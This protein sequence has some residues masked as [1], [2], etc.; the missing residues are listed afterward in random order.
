MLLDRTFPNKA[1]LVDFLNGTERARGRAGVTSN[2]DN[3]FSD[4]GYGAFVAGDEGKRIVLEG[5]GEFVIGS[6]NDENSVELV[7]APAAD[8]AGVHWRMFEGDAVSADDVFYL[9][10]DPTAGGQR[11][12]LI[13]DTDS[14][15]SPAL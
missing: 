11:L 7:E 9:G 3:T 2:G 5:Q 14:F 15:K 1:S 10:D 13:H 12:L 6:V 8:A 4:A